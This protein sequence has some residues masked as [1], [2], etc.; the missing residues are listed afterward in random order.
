MQG[1]MLLVRRLRWPSFLLVHGEDDA[2]E[3]VATELLRLADADPDVCPQ[4]RVLS[5]AEDGR[6]DSDIAWAI[7]KGIPYS[8]IRLHIR[9]TQSSIELASGS[10]RSNRH[11]LVR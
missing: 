2:S 5:V 3:E 10:L 11:F 6:G 4:R 1:I 8:L 7:S 9:Q